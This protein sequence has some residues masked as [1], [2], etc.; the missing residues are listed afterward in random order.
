MRVDSSSLPS[1]V[2]PEGGMEPGIFTNSVR[3]APISASNV[4]VF[5]TKRASAKPRS[6]HGRLVPAELSQSR[7]TTTGVFIHSAL[8]QLVD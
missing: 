6:V 3:F 4:V 7:P 5:A 1:W 8:C 2:R